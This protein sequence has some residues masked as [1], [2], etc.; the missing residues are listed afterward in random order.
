M[1]EGG[2]GG[3]D[4]ERHLADKDEVAKL[5]R[6]E[7]RKWAFKEACCTFHDYSFH[8]HSNKPPP[9]VDKLIAIAD[10]IVDWVLK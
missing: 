10:K 1:T 7:L 5:A 2:A 6:I 9:D 4:A 3:C 8:E